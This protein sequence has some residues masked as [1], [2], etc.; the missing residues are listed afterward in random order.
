ME[1]SATD[2]PFYLILAMLYLTA[3][4]TTLVTAYKLVD[5]YNITESSGIFIFPLTYL[6]GDIIAEVYG[7]HKARRIVWLVLFCEFLF[8]GALWIIAQTPAPVG[9]PYQQAFKT[10]LQPVFRF[11]LANSLGILV[12]SL[13]NIYLMAKWKVMMK[14]RSFWLRSIGSSAVGEAVTSMIADTLAFTGMMPFGDVGKLMLAIY[15]VKLFYAVV[16]ALPG[17][18]ICH[19]I[20]TKESNSALDINRLYVTL[21]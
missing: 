4:M 9:W 1:R 18:L 2:Q 15:A 16:L 3:A 20:K 12:G 13:V 10:V 19:Y 8:A 17:A 5:I 11:Y 14:G 7:Y 6:I 21:T